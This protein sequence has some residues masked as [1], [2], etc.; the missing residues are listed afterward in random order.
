MKNKYSRS[1]FLAER[2][3]L[4]AVADRGLSAK[5]MPVGNL[6]ARYSDGE[7]QI[8]DI[9]NSVMGRLKIYALLGVCPYEQLDVPME[10]SP[11][12]EVAKAI[13]I[14]SQTPRKCLLFH[15]Y[16]YNTIL[17]DNVFSEMEKLELPI[18]PVERDDF[19]VAMNRA[20]NNPGKA[21]LL[22]SILAYQNGDQ[23]E[24][25][26]PQHNTY[27]MQVLYRMWYHWPVT[28]LDYVGQFIKNLKN[29]DR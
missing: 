18:M 13:L 5:I 17:S 25:S 11:I 20:E 22:T 10:F 16:N 29:S 21:R 24:V 26:V 28:S 8:N 23:H 2:L 4:E 12:D 14:L 15:P 9:T 6:A 19:D 27:T 1:K 7:F 3:V